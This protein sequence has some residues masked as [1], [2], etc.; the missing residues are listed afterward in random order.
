MVVMATSFVWTNTQK[1]TKKTQKTHKTH[2]HTKSTGVH[3]KRKRNHC[4]KRSE[5]EKQGKQLLILTFSR[6]Q[7]VGL[8]VAI[9][10]S[11]HLG[12]SGGPH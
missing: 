4:K 12:F 1:N 3:Y 8:I 9:N 6:R 2:T 5:G 7:T 11:K 10:V